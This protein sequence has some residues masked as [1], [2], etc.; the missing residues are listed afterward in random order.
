MQTQND[1]MAL[2]ISEVFPPAIG[3][4]GELLK[5]IYSRF[6]EVPV[7]VLTDGATGETTDTNAGGIRVI[8]EQMQASR[9]GL[10]HPAGLYHHLK[11]AARI[12]HLCAGTHTVVHCGC[13]LPEGLDAWLAKGFGG[14]PYLCWAH[15]EELAHASSSR[16]LKMLLKQVQRRASALIANSRNTAAF[17]KQLG[18]RPH[19]ID[20]V[21]PG[22][23]SSRF[24][25]HVPGAAELRARFAGAGDLLLL[26]VGRLQRRKGHDLVLK[27]IASVGPEGPAIRY[28]IA[29]EGEERERLQQMAIALQV[30]DRVRL[31]GAVAA[32]E[33]PA[34][35][36]AADVFV[37]PNRVDD[38]DFEGFG[39]VFLEAAAAGL[40]VIGGASGGVPEA[41]EGGITGLL[42]PGRTPMSFVTPSWHLPRHR[43]D[44]AP[45]ELPGG[46]G[47]SVSFLGSA[48]PVK[49]RPFIACREPRV[50]HWPAGV[51][52]LTRPGEAGK[53]LRDADFSYP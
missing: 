34:Y 26:T 51:Q 53:G 33:L 43:R 52:T 13:T 31:V 22:V 17:L 1:V 21:H 37:H 46:R 4:S 38:G 3:G 29:G 35:Y 24:R 2:V 20:V 12:R 8:R 25:P 47:F 6:H 14:A 49:W 18:A 15:G 28:V 11:R 44:G 16:E 41:V 39:M 45:W 19:L 50:R 7:T 48:P 9:W 40:P 30:A 23:D 10:L 36:A 27:T 32:H 42:V 5:N